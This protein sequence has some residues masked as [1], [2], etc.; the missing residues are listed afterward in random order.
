MPLPRREPNWGPPLPPPANPDPR[1]PTYQRERNQRSGDI[2]LPDPNMPE[3]PNYPDQGTFAPGMLSGGWDKAKT[4]L[5][6]LGQS[7]FFTPQPSPMD[8]QLG[9]D[10]SSMRGALSGL[11]TPQDPPSPLPG[12]QEPD[13]INGVAVDNDPSMAPSPP[14]MPNVM[15][16]QAGIGNAQ[17]YMDDPQSV[18]LEPGIDLGHQDI[19]SYDGPQLNTEAALAG[20]KAHQTGNLN[21][22][23]G[24]GDFQGGA[25]AEGNPFMANGPVS[26]P[27]QQD[28]F[29]ESEMYRLA[30]RDPESVA[31]GANKYWQSRIGNLLKQTG[32]G[33]DEIAA[34]MA[35]LD[36][37][38]TAIQ[39]RH[40]AFQANLEDAAQRIALPA[41]AQAA[42]AIGAAQI[43]SEATAGK[44]AMETGQKADS[45]TQ[46][47]LVKLLNDPYFNLKDPNTRAVLKGLLDSQGYAPDPTDPLSVK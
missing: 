4:A 42:G 10:F 5:A 30:S 44:T 36:E 2:F 11:F 26:A 13:Q 14:G 47:T 6:G 31:P 25:P 40:P 43:D 16:Q 33:D 9:K 7:D 41:R 12:L 1:G 46:A 3:E 8:G 37:T 45:D 39:R 15:P 29:S 21:L 28:P 27:N 22:S 19:A 20:L 24:H 23:G 35:R 18:S 17:P 34:Q 38:N 32:R